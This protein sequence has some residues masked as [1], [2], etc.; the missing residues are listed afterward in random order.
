M[1]ASHTT[2][3][4]L[5]ERYRGCILGLAIG[6]ALGHPTEFVPSLPA[7]RSRW[8]PRGVTTFECTEDHPAGTFTDDTQMAV[9]AARAL[10]RAGRSD[11]DT[12]MAMLGV[13]FVAWSRSSENDR[14]PGGAC[15]AGCSALSS[16]AAWRQAG[17]AQSKGCGAAMRAAPFGLYFADD[18][19]T[20]VQTSAAQSVLTHRHPTGIASSVAAAAAVAHVCRGE[21]L[22]TLVDSVRAA[23]ERLDAQFLIDLGCPSGLAHSTGNGEMLASL[24]RLVGVQDVE[25][26]DVCSLLGQGWVGEEAVTAA[27]WCVLRA[28]GAFRDSVLRGANSSGDSDSIACIAGAIAGSLGGVSAIDPVWIS[29]VEK[30]HTLDLLAC[31]LYRAKRGEHIGRTEASLDLFGADRDSRPA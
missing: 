14:A 27:I 24:S 12:L 9:A 16:G 8:G 13:E 2:P 15:M 5:L 18:V 29:G 11:L 6:D 28:Q 17:V 1:T 19:P 10:I 30:T 21:D 26:D 25:S 20:M 23:V 31:T 22:A 7:I 3:T 4:P